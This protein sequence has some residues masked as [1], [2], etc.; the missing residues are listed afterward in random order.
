M[1]ERLQVYKCDV[2]GN[3][4]EIM[5]VPVSWFVVVRQCNF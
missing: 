4:I 5:A 1:A 3:I 2:C